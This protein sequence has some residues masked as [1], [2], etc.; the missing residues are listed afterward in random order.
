MSLIHYISVEF[1]RE[2]IDELEAEIWVL[3]NENEYLTRKLDVETRIH[4]HLTTDMVDKFGKH[5]W[6]RDELAPEFNDD[7]GSY[8][9]IAEAHG[10]PNRY[11]FKKVRK[12]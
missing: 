10:T 11:K 3:E 8:G 1:F 9:Y 7:G 5:Y 2:Q 12:S 6:R 4:T